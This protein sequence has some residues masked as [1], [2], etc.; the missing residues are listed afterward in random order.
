MLI[1]DMVEVHE[2]KDLYWLDFALMCMTG[3]EKK[4]VIFDEIFDYAGLELVHI[5]PSTYGKT[6]MLEAMLKKQS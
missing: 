1:P 3:Q 5:Y 4:R 2:N 6:V